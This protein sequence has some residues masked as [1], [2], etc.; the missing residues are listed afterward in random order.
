MLMASRR[1]CLHIEDGLDMTPEGGACRADVV[2]SH[3]GPGRDDGGTQGLH[4]WMGG[5]LR[6]SSP[7]AP[8][9]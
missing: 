7:H 4:V 6:E 2:R 9:H 5:W 8:R 1:C 3:A